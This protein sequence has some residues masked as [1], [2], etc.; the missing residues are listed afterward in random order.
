MTVRFHQGYFALTIILFVVEVL[1]AVFVR[2]NFVRPYLG[3]VLVVILMYAFI[4][5]FFKL[6]SI[7]VT[8]GVLLFAFAIEFLQYLHI[9]DKLGLRK[10]K[11]ISTILGTSF[12]WNDILAYTA[13]ACVIIL[14]IDP[15]LR[16][17]Q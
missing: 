6:R 12:S 5:T 1:I 11:L 8:L 13:G 2:D 3:D 4:K 10:S 7:S 15:M 9:L 16:R 17:R 14:V